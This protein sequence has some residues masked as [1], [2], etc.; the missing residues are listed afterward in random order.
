MA[1]EGFPLTLLKIP[2]PP[3]QHSLVNVQIHWDLQLTHFALASR[4]PT[5]ARTNWKTSCAGLSNT[6]AFIK[7]LNKVSLKPAATYTKNADS[8]QQRVS[9]SRRYLQKALHTEGSGKMFINI[10]SAKLEHG[11][12]SKL[13]LRENCSSLYSLNIF[14]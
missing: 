13:I 14:S 11:N 9:D 10:T 8:L 6:S 4:S 5:Q 7:Q 3:A 2:Y 1:R 12:D